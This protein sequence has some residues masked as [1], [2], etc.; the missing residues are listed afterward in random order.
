MPHISEPLSPRNIFPVLL[1]NKKNNKGIIKE[2]TRTDKKEFK[3]KKVKK[4]K[5]YNPTCKFIPSNIFIA[6]INNSRQKR[7][8]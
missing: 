3:M 6:L 1:R 5:K 7:V 8:K 2:T 4:I